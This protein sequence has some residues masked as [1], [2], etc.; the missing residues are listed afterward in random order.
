MTINVNRR[1]VL[2]LNAGYVP[3]HAISLRTA[4]GL[5][6]KGVAEGVDGV[7][8]RLRTPSTIYTVPSVIRLKHFVNVPHRTIQCNKRNVM[9]RDQFTC[10][11]CGV[12]VGDKRGGKVLERPNF[13]VDHLTP[14]SK[15]GKN[16]WSNMACACHPCNHRKGARTPHEAGL[17][18][19][20]EP[21]RPRTSY[22]VLGGDIPREWKIYINF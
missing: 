19:R 22:L 17:K 21:K 9:R 15:G 2:L 4:V 8:A 11:F 20:W 3:L 13:T 6:M 10:I 1:C 16:T 18:L 12:K 5:L 14:L 7:A